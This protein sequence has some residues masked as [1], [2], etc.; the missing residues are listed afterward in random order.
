GVAAFPSMTCQDIVES[1]H[2]NERGFIERL[3]HPEVGP[4]AHTG[5]PWH[6]DR[7]PNGVSMP[8]PC[9]GADTRALLADVLGYTDAKITELYESGV[10]N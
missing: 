1:P 8:A 3:E 7:R 10:L 6:L 4:R 2:L 9:L 5:V